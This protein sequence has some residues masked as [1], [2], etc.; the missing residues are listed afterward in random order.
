MVD[1]GADGTLL[2]KSLAPD[3]GLDSVTDL[4]PTPHGSGGAGGTTFPTWTTARP[5]TGQ[6]IAMLSTG[7]EPWG[8]EI[9][10]APVFADGDTALFGRSD[11]FAHFTITFDEDPNHGP[12]FHLDY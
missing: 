10:F 11:F 6:V 9:A 7:L 1:S 3:L 8:P 4:S 5:I 12:V 2:P